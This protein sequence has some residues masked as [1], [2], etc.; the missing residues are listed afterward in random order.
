MTNEGCDLVCKRRGMKVG[1][2][3]NINIAYGED[4]MCVKLLSGE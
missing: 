3:K 4:E 1:A 2:R